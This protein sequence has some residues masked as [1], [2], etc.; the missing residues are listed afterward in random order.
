MI[1]FLIIIGIG[2][3]SFDRPLLW[4]PAAESTHCYF[5]P[6]PPDEILPLTLTNNR[7]ACWGSCC[8]FP[9][10]GEYMLYKVLKDKKSQKK[11][12]YWTFGLNYSL[13][14]ALRVNGGGV[15][16]GEIAAVEM[17]Y[18]TNRLELHLGHNFGS[19]W[20]LEGGYSYMWG[21]ETEY[22]VDI[23]LS[24]GSSIFLGPFWD[25]STF[26]LSLSLRFLKNGNKFCG[27]GIEWYFTK[28]VTTA[29]RKISKSQY[30]E[31]EFVTTGM[32]PGLFG[33]VGF[34][35]ALTK[36]LKFN[37]SVAGRFA[38]IWNLNYPMKENVVRGEAIWYD[39]TGLY[40][41]IGIS[42]I[43]PKGAPK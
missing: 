29:N 28:G 11:E 4:R 35:P 43:F 17:F 24:D 42:Y 36:Q 32:A 20:E 38:W 10:A 2:F 14:S 3:G 39:F 40:L 33:E 7:Q 21:R 23:Y 22:L 30:E 6:Y 31:F 5:D 34:R 12:K 9:L 13:G 18:W 25:I 19:F 1:S 15:G 27:T 8:L 26:T 41:K 37:I 16:M